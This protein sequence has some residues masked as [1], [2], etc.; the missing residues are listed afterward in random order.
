MSG[1][2]LAQ[3]K[4]QMALDPNKTDPELGRKVNDHLSEIGA[5]TPTT[6]KILR[7]AESKKETIQKCVL[8]ILTELGMDM[9][10]DSLNA[11]PKRVAKMYV[12]ELFWGLKPENFPKS[13]VVDN[14]FNYDEMVIECNVTTQSSC[15]HHLLPVVG[16]TVVAYI[17]NVKVLG[18]SK[19]NRITEYFSRRP[20]IQER[21]TEQIAHTLA[22]ILDTK[23]VAVYIEAEHLCV[24]T[25]GVEDTNSYTV[26][27]KL[28]GAFKTNESTRQEFMAIARK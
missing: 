22:F 16:R 28:L 1:T 8:D 27:D 18:L 12:D 2:L 21:L 20:Q 13:T 5:Q 9:T 3:D 7:S 17:P 14:K 23:D 6:S 15:E 19:L 25:R 26:T 10:D 24:K 11:T 4:Y